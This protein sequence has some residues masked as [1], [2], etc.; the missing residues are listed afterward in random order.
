MSRYCPP[1]IPSVACASSRPTCGTWYVSANSPRYS[2]TSVR[3]CSGLRI[4]LRVSLRMLE[5]VLD[6]L[7]Q[8][9]QLGED[10][11]R[12]LGVVRLRKTLQLGAGLLE[13]SKQLLRP[14]EGI[15]GAHWLTCDH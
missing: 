7:A 12:L 3:S 8:L 4:D 15:L 13:S 6:R 5:L 9:G 14:G 2:S 11:E 1:I 10:V